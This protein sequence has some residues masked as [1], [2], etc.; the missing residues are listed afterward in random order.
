VLAKPTPSGI[1]KRGN[2]E[3]VVCELT[4]SIKTRASRF[5]GEMFGPEHQK[6]RRVT[7]AS[8][9]RDPM[10][11]R[12]RTLFCEPKSSSWSSNRDAEG[13]AAQRPAL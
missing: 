1:A 3:A 6:S 9:N 2:G 12:I 10:R 7:V 8:E 11:V 5:A 13:F 4:P